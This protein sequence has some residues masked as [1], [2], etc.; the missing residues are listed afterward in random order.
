MFHQLPDNYY[1]KRILFQM[2]KSWMDEDKVRIHLERLDT[3][4]MHK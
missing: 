4:S 3:H 1:H 2:N